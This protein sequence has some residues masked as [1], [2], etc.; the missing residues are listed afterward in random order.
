VTQIREGAKSGGGSR[1]TYYGRLRWDRPAYTINTFITRP[2]NG[3]FIHPV[4]ERLI[5]A[6]EAARLQSFPDGTSF[7]GPLR[8]RAKQIGNA[9]PPL[10]AYQI[11]SHVP[12]G[13]IVDL[14]CGAGG[15]SLGFELAGH[16]VVAAADSDRHA[17]AAARLNA[18]DGGTVELLDLADEAALRRLA[19][20]VKKRA[21]D[22]IAA[23]VG[24]PP[25]QGFS[26]AGPCRIGDERNLLVRTFLTAVRLMKPEVVL[27]ENV[28]ALMWRGSSFLQ[29]L[30]SALA[31]LGYQSEYALLHAEAYGVPQLRRRL[32][33][34]G[35]RTGQPVWP[36]PTHK[37][38]DPAFPRFQPTS[39][40]TRLPSA[41]TVRDAIG[42]IPRVQAADIDELAPLSEAKTDYQR[43]CRGLIDISEC[44][45]PSR[46]G[47]YDSVAN[48]SH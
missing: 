46:V 25:C 18:R 33:V 13:P 14:F 28:P 17:V 12:P 29:E 7:A 8:A 24:G 23:L 11:A 3:C 4:A 36:A 30:M 20:Q 1:S 43:W 40:E 15:M 16:E 21:P 9:V 45:G 39:S 5:S 10:L 35:T 47:F 37:V 22:G 19:R 27:M 44:A 2:G 38:R 6:R 31:S 34:Q 32:I 26:T 42:D 48:G 41:L